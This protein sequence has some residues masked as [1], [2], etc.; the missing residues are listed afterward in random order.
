[1]HKPPIV[2]VDQSVVIDAPIASLFGFL[3][4][5]EN[6]IRWYPNVVAIAS[7]NPAP[8]G[9]VGKLYR[10]TLR[11]PSGRDQVFDIQVVEC[12]APD[13]F[14]TEGTLKPL[15]PRM[16][17]RLT[18]TSPTR[19]LMTLRFLSR[20]PSALGRFLI[21]LLFKRTMVRQTK[22]GL[23]ALKTLIEQDPPC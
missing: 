8:H 20:S 15:F 19:T 2:L 4:N 11:L 18:A 13:L 17:V 6:Y 5:H 1:M 10:E 7:A 22:A 14:I 9:T 23:T 3:S 21:P 16:E 12:R